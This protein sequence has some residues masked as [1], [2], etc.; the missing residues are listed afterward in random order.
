[1]T[2]PPKDLATSL[3]EWLLY[4]QQPCLRK[5]WK[6]LRMGKPTGLGPVS[7]EKTLRRIKAFEDYLENDIYP[8]TDTNMTRNHLTPEEHARIVTL[9]DLL[10]RQGPRSADSLRNQIKDPFLESSVLKAEQMGL[11]E[12]KTYSLVLFFGISPPGKTW[13]AIAKQ[14]PAERR[15]QT[16]DGR[17]L[18]PAEMTVEHL[19]NALAYVVRS[20]SGRAYWVKAFADEIHKRGASIPEGAVAAKARL[21]ELEQ[22]LANAKAALA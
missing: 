4:E 16:K 2:T 8:N 18:T 1:M 7:F 13:L 15:W 17:S 10:N 20:P 11:L 22:R 19:F 12:R 9:L 5:W 21:D 14:P 3:K 6:Q